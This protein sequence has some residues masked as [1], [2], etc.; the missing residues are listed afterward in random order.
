MLLT[1]QFQRAAANRARHYVLPDQ[2]KRSLLPWGGTAGK[3]YARHDQRLRCLLPKA[4]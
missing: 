3:R 2:H 4:K 1:R